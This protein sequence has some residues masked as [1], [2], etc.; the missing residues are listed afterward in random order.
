MKSQDSGRDLDVA[1]AKILIVDD[2]P[3][4]IQVLGSTLRS[5]GYQ[6]IPATSGEQALRAADTHSPDLILLD[7]MMPEMDGYQ[8][9]AKL[10]EN[11]KTADIPV[12]FVTALTDEQDETKGLEMGAV[13]YI[14]KPIK[15]PVALARVRTH[16][17]LRFAYR[18]LA[19]QNEELIRAAELREDVDRIMRHDMKT[20]LTSVI[21]SP[22]LIR[23]L[24]EVN[25]Q[26]E[27][28]LVSIEKS[29]Y[30]LLNMVNLSL[31]LF[32][33]ERGSYEFEAKPVDVLPLV[34][35]IFEELT[36]L[37][38]ANSAKTVV[39]L[40]GKPAGDGSRF[41]VCGE[42]ALCYSMLANLIKNA[43]EASPEGGTVTVSLESVDPC[44]IRVHNG[45]AVPEE[46]RERFFEKY[47]TSGKKKG[48]GLGTYSARLMAETQRG[49]IE[50]ES[51][52][53]EGTTITVRLPPHS[54]ATGKT[55]GE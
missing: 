37:C 13:D 23:M 17:A 12:I 2:V 32:K 34:A 24:G 28:L 14:T 16:L 46:I 11:G 27:R 38:E 15:I 9:F 3:K 7:V 44:V 47:A 43:V 29:G 49:S 10:K 22:K 51:T 52:G 5:K 19:E 8:V 36:D 39:L 54:N 26:Q 55:A 4:N 40:D 6:V 20:P 48:T 35:R 53:P 25:D 41:L 45:G 33:M 30:R 1:T 21:A 50:L 42:E 18:K 31:D